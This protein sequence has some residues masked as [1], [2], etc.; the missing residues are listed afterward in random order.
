VK[1][2]EVI[3]RREKKL[4]K[5]FILLFEFYDGKNLA[6]NLERRLKKNQVISK[7]CFLE[8]AL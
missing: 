5:Y 8:W 7:D 1:L 6:E 4:D 3:D 2:H